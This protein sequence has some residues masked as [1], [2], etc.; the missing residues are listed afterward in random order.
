[1][2]YQV[3]IHETADV[4]GD[5]ETLED[6]EKYLDENEEED[7]ANGK[8]QAGWKAFYFSNVYL[9]GVKIDTTF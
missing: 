4:L 5:F 3:R 8:Y 2:K 1:M 7:K 6:A 9:D